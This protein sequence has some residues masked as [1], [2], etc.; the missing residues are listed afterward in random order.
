[1]DSKTIKIIYHGTGNWSYSDLYTY[2]LAYKKNYEIIQNYTESLAD[3]KH[4][5]RTS[6]FRDFVANTGIMNLAFSIELFF[7]SIIL[8]E[9][10]KKVKG[11][12]LDEL[13][14]ELDSALKT[15]IKD[16]VEN[17]YGKNLDFYKEL[18]INAK[19]FEK[20]R[21]FYEGKIEINILF[22]KCLSTVLVSIIDRNY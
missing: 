18:I 21:Y 20:A 14:A 12:M 11:H 10:N 4:G 22:L 7:K 6:E 2:G 8:K 3:K 19:S 15:E 17:M 1:M 13:Y 16:K 9:M 5:T